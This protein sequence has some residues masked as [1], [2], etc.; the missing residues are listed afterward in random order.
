MPACSNMPCPNGP[1]ATP[2]GAGR[3]EGHV[4]AAIGRILIVDDEE[5]NRQL[6]A[7]W[8][9]AYGHQ[10]ATAADGHEA[11]ALVE[12]EPPDAIILD[13]MMPG[14]DGFAV[15]ERL[16]T[17][18]KTAGIP[19]LLLTA[20]HER[21]DRLRGMR[22]GANDFLFKPADLPYVLLRVRNAV[23]TRQLHAEIERQLREVTR[24]QQLRESLLH[25]IVHDLRTPLAGLE[26][27]LQLLQMS[28]GEKLEARPA[29]YLKQA[30]HATHNFAHH[31]DLLLDI[32]RMEDGKMPVYLAPVDAADVVN[33]TL[34]PLRP[35]FAQRRLRLEIPSEPLPAIGDSGLLARVISNIIGNAIAFTSPET[36]EIKI[37][38]MAAAGRVRIEIEDN[39]PGIDP[40][41][42]EAIFDKFFQVGEQVRSRSSGLGL[43]FCK[44]AMTA[45]NGNIGV[46]S[47][48][49]SGSRF[50]FELPAAPAA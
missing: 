21:E 33:R 13:V 4:P 39:G 16:K 36:G 42:Q 25:M 11:L 50:W 29:H 17:N 44:L 35:L 6:L 7:E 43:A 10:I 23:H 48:P 8:L 30:L 14:M 3:A 28:A 2:S 37:R 22:A 15:C 27:F 26:G 19:V 18:P 24:E 49:G 1:S 38:A 20:L 40:S 47:R 12:Q 34:E 45:Q 32:H 46:T 41:K 9:G 31:I 5:P